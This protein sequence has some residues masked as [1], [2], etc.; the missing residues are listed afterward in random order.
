MNKKKKLLKSYKSKIRFQKLDL[1]QKEKQK[2]WTDFVQG[3][4]SKKKV[5]FHFSLEV[6]IAF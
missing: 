3:K 1:E 5:S 6:C 2:N 4:G